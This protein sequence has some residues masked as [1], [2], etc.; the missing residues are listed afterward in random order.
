MA[1]FIAI[2]QTL[3]YHLATITFVPLIALDYSKAFNTV[4]RD[5]LLCKVTSLNIPDAI[6]SWLV[7]F[8]QGHLVSTSTSP[9]SLYT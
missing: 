5:T 1:A 3:T 4:H 8:F 6:Y 9:P 2:M 7:D